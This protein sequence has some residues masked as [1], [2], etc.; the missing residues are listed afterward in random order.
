VPG[1]MHASCIIISISVIIIT[2]MIF[3]FF[4]M[5][6]NVST[7]CA[8][9]LPA[10]HPPQ[11]HARQGQDRRSARLGP[12]DACSGSSSRRG[13][14][15]RWCNAGLLHTGEE[16]SGSSYKHSSSNRPGWQEQGSYCGRQGRWR[17]GSSGAGCRSSSR[18]RRH[19]HGHYHRW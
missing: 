4:I 3:I 16:G 11:H 12:H 19:G 6:P 8:C 9:R 1:C 2:I 15:P 7:L 13:S 10:V 14:R 17:S 18:W 5:L